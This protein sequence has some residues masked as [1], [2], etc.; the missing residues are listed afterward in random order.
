MEKVYDAIIVGSG[1]TG[2]LGATILSKLGYDVLLLEKGQHPRFALGESATPLT[3][4][5]FEKFSKQYEIPELKSLSEYSMMKKETSLNCGPKELFYYMPHKLDETPV[6]DKIAKDEIVVQTR[7]VDLQYDRA[8]LDHYLTKLSQK[9]GSEYIDNITVKHVLFNED[10]VLVKAEKDKQDFEFKGKFIIDSTGFQSLLSKQMDL[11]IPGEKLDLPLNSRS[12]FTHFTGVKDLEAVLGNNENFNEEMPVH[13]RR[14]TQHHFFDGG[15]YWFIPFDNGVTSVG[16]CLDNE[17]YPMNEKTGEQEFKEFT[18]R[19]PIVKELLSEADNKMPYI[20]TGRMQFYSRKISGARWA[21]MP[22]AAMGLDAWQ[23]TGMTLSFMSLDRVI[24]TLH[25]LC[26]PKDDF[27]E[28]KFFPYEE[29]LKDEYFNLSYFVNGIY[30]SFKHKELMSMFCLLPFMGIE[31]F[32]IN[33]GLSRPWDNNAKLMS[34]GNPLW[35]ENFYRF[36]DLIIELNK[37]DT[38]SES[39]V[40]RA[41]EIMLLDMKEFNNRS[42]GCPTMN[43]IYMVNSSEVEDKVGSAMSVQEYTI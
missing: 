12:I 10:L 43:N 20:K 8:D 29:Q 1:V 42:Y 6:K 34:F 17:M 5:Y 31:H 3:T 38:L 2:S 37:K 32:V 27:K 7:T 4:Y 9:Y 14:G 13:R 26:Y 19:L 18:D 15:W 23:S 21:L 41:R 22:A 40:A 24:W 16:L 11:K 36:Y 33:G 25:N 39:D 35:K 28:E 30:K